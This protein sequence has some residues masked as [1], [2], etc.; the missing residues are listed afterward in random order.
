MPRQIVQQAGRC[1]EEHRSAAKA[2]VVRLHS[3]GLQRTLGHTRYFIIQQGPRVHSHWT[4]SSELWTASRHTGRTQSHTPQRTGL[5]N[6]T[7]RRTQS[8]RWRSL[9]QL[10][11]FA[12]LS[13]ADVC[14]PEG[15][16][17]AAGRHPLW[18][19]QQKAVSC[20]GAGLAAGAPQTRQH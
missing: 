5:R 8:S 12:Q 1:F 10:H 14:V 20:T 6:A 3:L 16:T 13:Q 11:A 17:P 15:V 2:L 18:K 7:G 4:G 9:L 19:S